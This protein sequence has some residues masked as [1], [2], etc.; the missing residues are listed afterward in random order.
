MRQQARRESLLWASKPRKRGSVC[1]LSLRACFI[2][3]LIKWHLIL[4][5]LF[6]IHV[7]L[8]C[9]GPDSVYIVRGMH[10]YKSQAQI[11][12]LLFIIFAVRLS[13]HRFFL[14]TMR[15][16]FTLNILIMI[17]WIHFVFF[18]R[19]DGQSKCFFYS[20]RKERLLFLKQF[21][22]CWILYFFC[23]CWCGCKLPA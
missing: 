11:W 13:T 9:S 23:C 7:E 12:Q 2:S 18:C 1:F 8:V 10:W 14:C 15:V 19:D 21:F 20:V 3:L 5:M 22:S 4:D 6:K 16:F 17:S